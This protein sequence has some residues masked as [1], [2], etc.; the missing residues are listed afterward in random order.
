MSDTYEIYAIRYGHHDRKAHE[1]FLG[2][3]PHD[4]A[5]MPL[6]YF[7]WAIVGEHQTFVLDTGFAPDMA[8]ARGRQLV[9]PVADGL[10]AIGIEPANVTDVIL[11]HMHYDHAGNIPLFG[12]ARFHI[13]DAEMGFVTGRAMC[14]AAIRAPFEA[15]HVAQMV[16]RVFDGRVQFH[17]GVSELAPGLTLHKVGGHTKGLQ[18]VRVKTRRGHVVLASDAAHLYANL[19]RNH[20]FPI[21]VDID[22]YLEAFK[23][24]RRLASS[25][26]HIVPGHDP[27][28]LARYPLAK[29]GLA[30][31]VRLDAEPKGE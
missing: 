3:D 25:E 4:D 30:G 6:D 16:H 8:E 17:D 26:A 9:R 1:N 18:V 15:E 24:I 27:L 28:V 19:T 29:P 22:D 23:T 5:P 31:V 7:V 12:K 14:H 13:Q 10:N 21:V 20:P 2:A 11:S